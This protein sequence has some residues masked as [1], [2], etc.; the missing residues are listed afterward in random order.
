[1][2]PRTILVRLGSPRII[3]AA[4]RHIVDVFRARGVPNVA[5]VWTMMAWTMNPSSGRNAMDY[6]P[7]DAYVDYVGADGTTGI[8]VVQEMTGHRSKTSSLTPTRSP[9]PTAS[10]GW[11]WS[12]EHRRT[13]RYR[14]ERRS[15]CSTRLP[16]PRRGHR[17]R[18]SSTSLCQRRIPMGDG[19]FLIGDGGLPADRVGSV[20]EPHVRTRRFPFRHRVR[21]R[22]PKAQSDAD[23]PGRVR[24]RPP[25][26]V[27]LRP[28]GRVRLRLR[29]RLHSAPTPTPTPTPIQPGELTTTFNEGTHGRASGGWISGCRREPVRQDREQQRI[30]HPR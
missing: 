30:R 9:W 12:S 8:R 15:G 5:F 7:G 27:R 29:L 13:P 2:S 17:S 1:M 26:R 3:A 25:G 14:D 6:Y 20:P 10:R 24:R 16:P 22:P 28:H 4:F 18:P 21:H 19:Q 11:W 23:P